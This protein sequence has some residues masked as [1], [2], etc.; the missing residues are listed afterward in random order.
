VTVAKALVSILIPA[1]NERFF[2]EALGSALAQ[3]YAPLEIIVCDDSSGDGIERA[4]RAAGC[5]HMRYVR[6][7]QRRGFAGN[8][9]HCF[10]LAGGK[11]IKFLNDDDRL[12]PGCVAS[13][14]GVL[15]A[16][17]AA[18]LATSRRIVIDAAGVP[19]PDVFSTTPV[20]HVSALF[21]GRELGDYVLANSTN[22]IG[23][24]TT[25]L[26]RREALQ[27]EDGLLFRWGGRDYHCLAD[28][29]LWLRLLRRGLAYYDAA[30]LSE[31][32]MHGGQEQVHGDTPLACLLERLE[33]SR[34]ARRHGFLA[35]PPLWRITLETVRARARVWETVQGLDAATRATLAAF[36]ADVEAE[37]AR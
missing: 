9:T 19:Q 15:E 28:L 16:Q 10:S 3:T 12:R 34:E 31:Y 33:I 6:N 26:F 35:S 32:R 36:V 24:P 25:A 18:T 22:F 5:P 20:S 2:G 23:E 37:L 30:T 29:S 7:P 8:F 4:V 14:A 13:L 1:Y 11:Y 17:P 21:L 27:L